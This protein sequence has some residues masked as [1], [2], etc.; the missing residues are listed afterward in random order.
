MTPVYLGETVIIEDICSTIGNF[1]Q[2]WNQRLNTNLDLFY[3][4]NIFQTKFLKFMKNSINNNCS[5]IIITNLE[6]LYNVVTSHIDNLKIYYFNYHYNNNNF[7]IK[8]PLTNCWLIPSLP[9]NTSL[10]HF[11]STLDINDNNNFIILSFEDY[12]RYL[13]LLYNMNFPS[14]LSPVDNIFLTD[15]NPSGSSH[16]S[17]CELSV[18]LQLKHLLSDMIFDEKDNMTDNA[19]KTIMEKISAL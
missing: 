1:P 6:N 16:L 8:I 2:T 14:N 9:I 13:K 4:F 3:G 5:F 11:Y 10:S 12:I 19:F 7:S 18:P 17:V 15:S